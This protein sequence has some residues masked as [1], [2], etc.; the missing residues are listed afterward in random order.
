MWDVV[1]GTSKSIYVSN[2][3]RGGGLHNYGLAVDISILD[4]NGVP[5]PTGTEVDHMGVEAHITHE[6]ELVKSGKI[7]EEAVR[8]RQLLRLIMREAGFRALNSEW[9]HFNLC[10]REIAKQ[11]YKRIE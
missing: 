1:K 3:S 8:N 10:S 7:S 9:W 2:P 6:A 4:N 11:K 5:L